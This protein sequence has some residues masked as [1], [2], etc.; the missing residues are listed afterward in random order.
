MSKGLKVSN[1]LKI[2]SA[3]FIITAFTAFI[4][5][6]QP[7]HQNHQAV[8]TFE[9]FDDIIAV[10]IPMVSPVELADFLMKQE[11]HYNLINIQSEN[12]SADKTT[13]HYFIPTAEGHSYESFLKLNIPVNESIFLYSKSEAEA[14]QLY[15]LLVIRGYFK[16]KVLKGGIDAWHQQ[17]LNPI[18]SDIIFTD[19]EHRKKLTTFFGGNFNNVAGKFSVE[20][21]ILNKKIK[22]HKGC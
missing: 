22:K 21:I 12:I 2:I 18:I 9:E 3:L 20:K 7:K 14:V 11:H 4:M 5:D 1:G 8:M 17:I 19:Q 13:E 10:P 15:Y 16:V 6:R